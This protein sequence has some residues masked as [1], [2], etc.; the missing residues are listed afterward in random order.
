MKYE[1]FLS[2]PQSAVPG[3][4]Y[5]CGLKPY[6]A[7]GRTYGFP[8]PLP[9]GFTT[10]RDR[11]RAS[12]FYARAREVLRLGLDHTLGATADLSAALC[13]NW[14]FYRAADTAQLKRFGLERMDCSTFHRHFLSH[15][16]PRL[17]F[18]IGN[19][20]VSSYAGMCQLFGVQTV[21]EERYLGTAK[22]KEARGMLSGGA[23]AGGQGGE[24]DTRIIG[25]PHLSRFAVT[26]QLT[27]F[28]GST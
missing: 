21:R 9:A 28:V 4:L 2:A 3:G 19:G 12:P 24:Q 17:I 14:F 22:L 16:R 27:E 23:G 13:T 10:Y 6:G 7:P 20:A 15:L 18:C 25:I 26:A 8:E 1:V 11:P 5:F